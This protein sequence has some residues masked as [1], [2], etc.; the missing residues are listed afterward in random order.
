MEVRRWRERESK[1]GREGGREREQKREGRMDVH[2]VEPMG[3][4]V[5]CHGRGK[6][7]VK[8]SAWHGKFMGTAMSVG[9]LPGGRHG[10]M[11]R[12]KLPG[13]WP[14][15]PAVPALEP[16]AWSLDGATPVEVAVSRLE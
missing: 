14:C 9:L 10:R 1:R 13:G 11:R 5:R 16:A 7:M 4:G 15:P 8:D 2:E 6:D 12:L 3:S